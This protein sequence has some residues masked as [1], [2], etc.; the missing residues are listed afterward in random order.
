MTPTVIGAAE[1]DFAERDL[2]YT[3]AMFGLLTTDREFADHNKAI[4]QGWLTDLG[5]ARDPARPA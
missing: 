4:M 3:A 1:H 5:A 2:R